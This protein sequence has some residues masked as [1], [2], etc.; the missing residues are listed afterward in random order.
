M[1]VA[2]QNGLPLR[3]C[4]NFGRPFN[5]STVVCTLAGNGQ[6]F[7]QYGHSVLRLLGT[8]AEHRYEDEY[9]HKS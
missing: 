9:M 2:F 5:F 8:S 3:E 7:M 4:S 6:V 1:L